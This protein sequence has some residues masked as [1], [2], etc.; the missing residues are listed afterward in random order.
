MDGFDKRLTPARGDIAAA[1]LKGKVEAGRFVE[2]KARQVIAPALALRRAP[3]DD[4][5]LETQ[6][7]FGD[8]F[9]IYD[10]RDG[11]VWGQSARDDY[12]G[13]AKAADLTADIAAP[14]HEIA[15]LRTLAFSGPDL[16]SAPKLALSLSSRVAITQTDGK[17]AKAA[18]AGWIYR[19]HLRPIGEHASGDWVSEAEKF[20]GAPYLW[21]GKD[22][23]GLDCSGLMQTAMA[24]AGL[25]APRDTDMQ[26][27]GLGAP[28]AAGPDLQRLRRGDLIFW[29]GH[30]GIMANDDWLI[31]ASGHSMMVSR[32][33]LADAVARIG[34]LYGGPTGFRRP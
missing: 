31:H 12:V 4:A 13:W 32:E 17:W 18:H 14:T 2:G 9:T 20:L 28:V 26:E 21:G 29:K 23:F 3:A 30:V 1:H 7:L 24:S 6:A 27:A 19:A 22:S 34:Y 16:K 33:R 11:W 8:G 15:V 10:E 25:S 5:M